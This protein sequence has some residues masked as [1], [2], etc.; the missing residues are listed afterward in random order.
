MTNILYLAPIPD[1]HPLADDPESKFRQAALI[2][3]GAAVKVSN[4]PPIPVVSYPT[5]DIKVFEHRDFES[6]WITV[7]DENGL[8]H[9][10]ASEIKSRR[11]LLYFFRIEDQTD[12]PRNYC[13]IFRLSI[14]QRLHSNPTSDWQIILYQAVNPTDGAKQRPDQQA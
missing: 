11:M 10:L 7:A 9:R 4:H 6:V 3:D 13:G 14:L 5:D 2:H 12:S 1:D 8:A